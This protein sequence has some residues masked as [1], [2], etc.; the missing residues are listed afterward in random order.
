MRWASRGSSSS[1][2][3]LAS[4]EAVHAARLA[5]DPAS[6]SC[7]TNARSWLT[8]IGSSR[9]SCRGRSTGTPTSGPHGL[10]CRSLLIDLE[11]F[12]TGPREWDLVRP[13]FQPDRSVY[14]SMPT[15]PSCRL[16]RRHQIVGG[17]PDPRR[18]RELAITAGSVHM[19]AKRGGF[20]GI[21][22]SVDSRGRGPNDDGTRL[23]N[24][25]ISA[26]VDVSCRAAAR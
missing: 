17:I 23:I 16:W 9:S 15:G 6:R 7:A 14:P 21:S 5:V 12:A 26:R 2:R 8:P 3:S 25:E 11:K 4:V 10:G 19:G 22:S 13:A 1:H 18:I 20:H 24:P